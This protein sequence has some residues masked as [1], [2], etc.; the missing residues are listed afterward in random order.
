[1]KRKTPFANHALD[2]VCE[3][4]GIRLTK[5]QQQAF[6]RML[7]NPKHTIP[8]TRNRLACY[9]EGKWYLLAC[10]APIRTMPT[11]TELPNVIQS[12]TMP[13]YTVQTFLRLEDA[14]DDDKQILRHDKRYLKIN[15]DAFHVLSASHGKLTEPLPPRN[16]RT[17]E[18]PDVADDELP[19]DEIQSAEGMLNAL[20]GGK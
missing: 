10:N 6:G 11:C 9:F 15:N 8:L 14:S 2:R 12:R 18:L 5:K 17:V 16:K 1:M 7:S 20:C 3:R 13:R 4:C 19:S